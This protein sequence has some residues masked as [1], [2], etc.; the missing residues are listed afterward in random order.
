M[1]VSYCGIRVT[2]PH[3]SNLDYLIFFNKGAI[4]TAKHISHQG[5][6]HMGRNARQNSRRPGLMRGL[7]AMK[8]QL[9]I[10]EPMANLA[11]PDRNSGPEVGTPEQCAKAEEYANFLR[12]KADES[13]WVDF[14]TGEPLA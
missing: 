13:G 3:H 7:P 12:Q 9:Q 6:T 10:G 8:A 11:A 2:A 5:V 14:D 4:L 1:N